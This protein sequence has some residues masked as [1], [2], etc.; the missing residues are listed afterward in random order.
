MKIQ[1]SDHFN[2]KRL[3]R[4]ILPSVLM[5]LCTSVYSIVDGFFVS[6]FVGKTQFAAVNLIMPIL[7]GVGTIGFMIG[8]GGSAIV[9]RTMGEGKKELA[10]Q[11]FSMLIY[12][13]LALGIAVSVAG[14]F[15]APAISAALGATGELLENC[16]L[17]ARI[18]FCGMPFF[19]LQYTFQSFF[20]AAEKPSLS[21]KINVAAGLTNAFLDFLLIIVFRMGLAGAAVAT[22]IGQ[23]IGGAVPLI[24]FIRKNKSSLRLVKTPIR[25][26]VLFKACVNGSSEM[27]TNLSASVINILYNFQL[28][29]LAGVNGVAAYGIIMYVNFI[30]MAMYLGYAMGS[31]PIVSYHY[32]AG[33]HAELK[34]IFRKSLVVLGV[35]SI[36][37]VALSELGAQPLVSIFANGDAELLTM[38]TRGFRLYALCFLVMGFNVWGSSFFTALNNGVVSA[39]IS[40]LRTFAFQIAAVMLL[41]LFFGIDGVWLS[42]VAAELLSLIATVV[43]LIWGRKR[44][45]YC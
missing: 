41:P 8:T 35:A 7:F 45:R 32:G 37:L 9:S 31:A 14:F 10:N 17:Y 12:V 29:K 16:V 15:L 43:F 2:Y 25:L 40:F 24:Y 26:K 6:N 42:I 11:Y 4:F 18:L 39:I 38:T 33:N 30:F 27:V 34:N 20:V 44:Y 28:M 13:A 23:A 22:V 5:I 3:L 1:L 21:L 19:I 36:I